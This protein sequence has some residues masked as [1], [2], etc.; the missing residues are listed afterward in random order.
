MAIAYNQCPKCGSKI[1]VKIVYGMPNYE[2]FEEAE[3]GKVKLGGCMIIEGSPEYFCME[4]EHEWNKEQ[5]INAAYGRIKA[6][7]ASV[8]GYFGGY[9]NVDV[10]LVDLKSTW[11]HEGGGED[12]ETI[13]KT[14]RAATANKFVEE[15]KMLNLLDWKAKYI[16]PD[17]CDGTQWSVE[18]ITAGRTIR[19]VGDN[20]FPEEWDQF[21]KTVRKLTNKVFR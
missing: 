6:I 5:A 9:Y 1:S 10:D 8:G 19:K 15:L 7:K 21:C 20:Q 4:C 3:A 14:I 2:L 11:S 17:M 12:E 13:Y 18:I 16:E